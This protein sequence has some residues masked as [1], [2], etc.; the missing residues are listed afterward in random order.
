MLAG[1][2]G[3][4]LAP[5]RGLFGNL[6]PEMMRMIAAGMIGGDPQMGANMALQYRNARTPEEEARLRRFGGVS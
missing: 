6:D 1:G 3:K 5:Q 4:G 2:V